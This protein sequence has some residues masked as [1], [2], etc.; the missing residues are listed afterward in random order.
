M[1]ISAYE[2]EAEVERSHWWY[3]GRRALFGRMIADLGIS[4][5][6]R[7]LDI[8]SSTG[9]NLQM[10]ADL[11]FANVKGLDPNETAKAFCAQKGLTNV[12][13]GDAQDLP[14]EDNSM[15]LI[16]ATDVMEHVD[17]DDAAM[18]EAFRVL[19]PGGYILLTVPAFPGLWGIQDEISQHKRRYM[20]K[21]FRSLV[22][23]SGFEICKD[24]YFNYLLFVPIFLARKFL[25]KFRPEIRAEFDINSKL[26]NGILGAIFSLDISTAATVRPPFGVSYLVLA[27]R[28]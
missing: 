23:G 7:V 22:R 4:R 20:K 25:I 5:E 11:G 9:T 17:H 15:D 8:G 12:V 19:R 21:N 14:F 2:S 16:L 28:P 27:R 26:I 18:D 6:S 1:E 13:K 10:L 3:V 24:F